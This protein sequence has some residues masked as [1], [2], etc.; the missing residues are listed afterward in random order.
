MTDRSTGESR[1]NDRSGNTSVA[2]HAHRQTLGPPGKPAA[3]RRW[4]KR[5]I[6]GLFALFM[7]V[8]GAGAAMASMSGGKSGNGSKKSDPEA[9]NKDATPLEQ[10]PV[11]EQQ[12]VN[13]M[14]Y[15]I[16][17]PEQDHD[18]HQMPVPEEPQQPVT[19]QRRCTRCRQPATPD[20]PASPVTDHDD[21]EMP[22]PEEP[23]QPVQ[24]QTGQQQPQP[25]MPDDHADHDTADGGNTGDQDSAS[26]PCPKT[27]D[28]VCQ[29]NCAD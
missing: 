29:C 1:A 12:D 16:S 11:P 22:A 9:A 18:D 4:G 2:S 19:D 6:S 7:S 15:Y 3:A 17:D 5:M 8:A 23:Q 26:G 14:P 21:H 13:Q 27:G 10:P 28:A 20:E 25:P 24:D